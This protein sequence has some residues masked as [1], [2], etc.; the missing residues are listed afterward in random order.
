MKF[1]LTKAF[2]VPVA[3]I[4]FL[5]SLS[6]CGKDYDLVSDYVVR[7]NVETNI[8]EDNMNSQNSSVTSIDAQ[9]NKGK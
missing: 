9:N 5:L 6:S 4:V 2:F 3:A 1:H 7:E 8:L